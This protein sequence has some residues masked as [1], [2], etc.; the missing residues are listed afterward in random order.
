[1]FRQTGSHTT[2]MFA[3]IKYDAARPMGASSQSKPSSPSQSILKS[4]SCQK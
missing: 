4:S 3:R 1:M 2:A